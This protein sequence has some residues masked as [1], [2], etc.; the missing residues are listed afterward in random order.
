MHVGWSEGSAT[1]LLSVLLLGAIV[2]P[3]LI[4]WLGDHMGKRKLVI[5]L[6]VASVAGAL[7]WPFILNNPFLAYPII[8]MWGG[9]FVVIYTIM[10]AVVGSKF[11]GE[12]LVSVYSVLSIAWGI[13][14]FIGPSSAGAAMDL[15]QHGLPIF[16][17]IPSAGFT[18]LAVLFP[19]KG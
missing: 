10:V 18:A 15:T 6:G 4:G 14:A 2:M 7:V 8:F 11:Q 9:L 5:G 19:R 1:L 17:A 12:D 16:A 13:G 3:L